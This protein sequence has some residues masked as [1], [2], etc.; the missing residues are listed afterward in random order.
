MGVA[1]KIALRY[2]FSGKSKS[3]IGRISGISAAGMAVGTAALIVILS[4]YNG[5]DRIIRDNRLLLR[6]QRR[7]ILIIQGRLL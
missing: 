7:L 2:L 5:F 4:V 3:V 1:G 6:G